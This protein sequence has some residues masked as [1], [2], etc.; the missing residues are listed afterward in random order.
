MNADLKEKARIAAME[1]HKVQRNVKLNQV[2]QV[3][4]VKDYVSKHTGTKTDQPYVR[5]IILKRAITA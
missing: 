5:R 3:P 1:N 4:M 2:L